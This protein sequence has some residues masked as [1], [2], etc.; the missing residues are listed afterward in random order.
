MWDEKAVIV[1]DTNSWDVTAKIDT[2]RAPFYGVC[3]VW[4]AISSNGR[5]LYAL[6]EE[7]DNV[8]IID[9]DSNTV[10]GTVRVGKPYPLFLPMTLKNA[11]PSTTISGIVTNT[12]G[13][14][15]ANMH[16][17]LGS[18]DTI[19]AC[20]TPFKDTITS[21]DGS[22]RFTVDAGDYL[23]YINSNGQT[24][25]Y[26]PEAYANINNWAQINN[27]ARISLGIGEHK[28][29]ANLSLPK[30]YTVTGRL[31]DGSGQPVLG[32]GANIQD[33]AKNI[34]FGCSFGFGSSDS[35]G[36]FQV[37]VPAGTYDLSFCKDNQCYTVIKGRLISASVNLGDVLFAEAP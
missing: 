2:G 9:A 28:S 4:L 22:Y 37:N 35:D 7:S 25:G 19:V 31:V 27:A 36:T 15:L 23:V 16:V 10:V 5:W 26:I 24:G 32:A 11:Q 14:P 21:S 12:S 33:N 30:G 34:E 13:N 1:F 18:Y 8:V 29:D 6:G 17:N 20:G 3:P